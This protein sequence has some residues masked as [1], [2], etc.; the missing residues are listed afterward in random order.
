VTRK[1][2]LYAFRAATRRHTSVDATNHFP[3]RHIHDNPAADFP[4]DD[5]FSRC[6]NILK[7]DHL[8]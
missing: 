1:T 6:N 2:T 8:R 4:L 7:R 3:S 5:G